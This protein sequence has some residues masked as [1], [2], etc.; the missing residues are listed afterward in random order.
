MSTAAGRLGRAG[1]PRGLDVGP[2]RPRS[3]RRPYLDNLKVVLVA[4][5]ILGHAC[6]TYGDLGSWAY[7]EPSTSEA[8]NLGAAVIVSLGSLFAMGT[9]FLV[10]GLLT[11]GP[12]LRKGPWA[13]LRDRALRLG[14]PFAAYLLLMYPLVNWL[15]GREHSLGW[16]L[17]EQRDRLDPGPLWFVGVLFLFSAA[18][19]VWRA[20][21]PTPRATG[22]VGGTFLMWLV[23][24]IAAG[25]FVVR[26]WYPID[27]FQPFAAHLWQWPQ[28][29]GLFV[30]GVRAAEHGGLEPVR[31]R[32]RRVGGWSA[33]AATAV[34]L[35]A[36]ATAASVDPF[37]GG[38][39]WKAMLTAACEGAIAVGLS[40]WLMGTFQRHFDHAGRLATALGR[41]AFGAY[42]LQAPV[43]VTIAVLASRVPATPEVR[44]LV[45]APA[46]IAGSFGLAWVL[47][48]LPGVRWLL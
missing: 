9:F 37:A 25:T 13:F 26:L 36:L 47:T 21:T 33:L 8:F 44:F 6:I 3:T 32:I 14:I 34:V 7:H 12:V 39:T 45:V 22:P 18:Y 40:V 17:R 24:A 11:P 16:Y 42:V 30:L 29:L 10:A 31:V 48:Q 4:G 1:P 38:T 23:V 15:G 35:A 43:L 41:A 28:C 2:Q 46:A 27:S 20:M 19:A 5:V